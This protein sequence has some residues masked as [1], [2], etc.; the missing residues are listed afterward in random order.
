VQ[1]PERLE[2]FKPVDLAKKTVAVKGTAKLV[3]RGRPGQTDNGH[4]LPPFGSMV[5]FGCNVRVV[6]SIRRGEWN[7]E[8]SA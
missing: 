8:N 1:A 4:S 3:E 2:G 5:L 7:V 6:T